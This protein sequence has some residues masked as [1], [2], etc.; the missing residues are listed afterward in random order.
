MR[1]HCRIALSPLGGSRLVAVAAPRVALPESIR[2]QRPSFLHSPQLLR[3]L[4]WLSL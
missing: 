4:S 3:L 2:K 1:V